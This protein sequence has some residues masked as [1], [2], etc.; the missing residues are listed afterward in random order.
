VIPVILFA[1]EYSRG[2]LYNLRFA[3]LPPGFALSHLWIASPGRSYG[4]SF[5]VFWWSRRFGRQ[6]AGEIRGVALRLACFFLAV[7]T[8]GGT[9]RPSGRVRSPVFNSRR[10][11][12]RQIVRHSTSLKQY[13]RVRLLVR[14]EWAFAGP[15]P[16][17]VLAWGR[18]NANYLIA[19]ARTARG[20]TTTR[21][22][23]RR[24]AEGEV[25]LQG[26]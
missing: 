16:E 18:D 24:L 25:V 17:R 2:E 19:S 12:E 13:D 3:G 20:G 5:V 8:C 14:A 9:P 4:F 21:H 26:R 10:L 23:V 7:R 15:V 1:L 11:L 22:G 6:P